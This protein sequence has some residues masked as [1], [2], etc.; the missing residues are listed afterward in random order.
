M[1]T[2]TLAFAI[3]Q[4]PMVYPMTRT[5]MHRAREDAMS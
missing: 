2:R 1:V 3:A 4:H 5:Q